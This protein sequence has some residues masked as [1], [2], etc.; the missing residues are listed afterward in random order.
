MV[1]S[2]DNKKSEKN[3]VLII[4][5]LHISD[6]YV[7]NHK[8]YW[9]ECVEIISK[10][11]SIIQDKGVTH[12][13]LTGDLVG[14]R[15]KNFKQRA[16]LMV[17]M[18]ALKK[19]NELTNNNV[20]TLIGNHDISGKT[21]DFELIESLGL[22]KTTRSLDSH[23]V[24]IGVARFHLIDYGNEN[25]TVPIREGA[26]VSNVGITHADIQI[27]GKTTWWYPSNVRFELSTMQNWKGIEMIVAGHIHNPSPKML[28]TDIDGKVVNLFYVG[29]PTRPKKGDNWGSCWGTLFDVDDSDINATILEIPLPQDVFVQTIDEVDI[30]EVQST[31]ITKVEELAAILNTLSEYKLNSDDDIEGQIKRFSGVDTEAMDLALEYYTKAKSS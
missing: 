9:G 18:M 21:T 10:V 23:F 28:S 8:D 19:W 15:E 13:I 22:V 17:F 20:Y 4:G 7:G 16:S 3:R 1:N 14:L 31:E 12:L 2:T 29:C 24:D 5:D 27:T 26:G 6:A 11:T 25:E 30:E